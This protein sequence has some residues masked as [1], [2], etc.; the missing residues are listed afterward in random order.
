MVFAVG[1]IVSSA[2]GG[3]QGKGAFSAALITPAGYAFAI[4]GVITL[5]CL[6]YGVYQ[7]LPS[8]RKNKLYDRMAA[9]LTIT[10]IGFSVWLL[11]AARDWLWATVAIFVVMLVS[12][13]AA[14]GQ[15][16]KSKIKLS[17]FESFLIKGTLGLYLGWSTVAIVLNVMAALAYY[18]VIFVDERSLLAYIGILLVALV[19]ALWGWRRIGANYYYAGTIIWAFVAVAVRTNAQGSFL[20]TA[21][22]AAAVVIMLAATRFLRPQST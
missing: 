5:G 22:A 13:W 11:A 10:F 9:P 1:Q 8:Q 6:V 21:I 20:L 3:F 4:W 7:L 18:N 2:F 17:A 14:Y 19:H 15:L 12:L 16:Q